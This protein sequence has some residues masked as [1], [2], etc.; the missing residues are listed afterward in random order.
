MERAS[1]PRG[2]PGRGLEEHRRDAHNDQRQ[3]QVFERTAKAPVRPQQRLGP[4]AQRGSE[5]VRGAQSRGPDER[6]GRTRAQRRG[7]IAR[8]QTGIS[9]GRR[10]LRHAHRSHT[11][12]PAGRYIPRDYTWLIVGQAA[13]VGK[14]TAAQG[15]RRQVHA[16]CAMAVPK[17][18]SEQVSVSVSGISAGEA[19][20][21]AQLLLPGGA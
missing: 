20:S 6:R 2:K 11:P 18:G 21:T 13:G 4:H 9:R 19:C 14:V 16:V 10:H 15:K 8:S 1:G 3:N 5:G 7:Q 12:P 17:V